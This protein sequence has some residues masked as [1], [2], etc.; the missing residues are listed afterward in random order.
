MNLLPH[1]E[2]YAKGYKDKAFIVHEGGTGK[3]ICACVWLKDGRDGY[4]MIVCPKRVIHKWEDTLKEWG[5][6]NYR[7][8]SK[9]MFK[10]MP[11]L[12]YSALVIDEA[13]EFASPLFLKGRSQLS[14]S[15]YT[16]IKA[17]PNMPVAL[18]TATPIRSSPWN[19]HT[20]LCY[21]G[22]YHDWKK[23][24][25]A[26]FT[27]ERRPFISYLAWMPKKDWRPRIRK[28]LE[29][30]ADIVLLKDCV[31]YLPP[32]VEIVIKTKTEKFDSP[33]VVEPGALFVAEHRHEQK[34][35]HKNIVEIGKQYRKILVV[36]HYVEQAESLLKEL[37]KDRKTY[38]V[39]GGIKKQEE[40]L[41]EA[42]ECDEC[43]LIV[44]ASLGVGWDGDSFSCV[45]FASMSYKVRDFVQLKYRVRRIH[46]LHPVNYY[47]I[48]GGRCDKRVYET[49]QLGRDFIPSEWYEKDKTNKK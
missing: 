12:R 30:Y 4:A 29:S 43:F 49:I 25:N 42:N 33:L 20:L 7:V 48:I 26:F 10:K 19:L 38:L 39:H 35:K 23:W 32:T 27:L 18:L 31:D 8:V 46:A 24:R 13:D 5:V 28:V 44:Q 40:I 34:N 6:K 16:Q 41:K 17:Y 11:P 37:S 47:Y 1:Q 36:A 3:T 9:E 15:L 2:K 14:T 22:I 45:V 21:L